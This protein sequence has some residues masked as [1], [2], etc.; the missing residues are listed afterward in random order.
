MLQLLLPLAEGGKKGRE[1]PRGRMQGA[2][3]TSVTSRPPRQSRPSSLLPPS[4]SPPTHVALSTA[5][6]FLPRARG[7]GRDHAMLCRSPAG[8]HGS[9]R[10][11]RAPRGS[12]RARDEGTS[13]ERGGSVS[14]PS[15]PNSCFPLPLRPRP[16]AMSISDSAD[17]AVDRY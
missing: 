12:A 1:V 16:C 4:S 15:P 13:E 17:V 11:W 9:R 5:F 3:L 2:G 7:W 6:S 8:R 10:C 14:E